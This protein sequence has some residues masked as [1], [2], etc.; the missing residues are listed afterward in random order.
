MRKHILLLSII[1][2]FLNTSSA[3]ASILLP[4][5]EQPNYY[6][7]RDRLLT[8]SLNGTWKFKLIKD[9]NV[10]KEY[11]GWEQPTFNTSQ[12]D[13]INVPGNWETQGLK[14]PE[15]GRDLEEYIGLYRTTFKYNQAWNHKNVIL[16]FDGV[17]FGYEC[18]INGNKVGSFGSA[19]N[20]CQ[21][22]ITPFLNTEGDNVLSV[23]VSTR[24]FGWLF[25]TNDCWSL[26]GIT[27]DVELFALDNIY[28]EDVTYVSDVTQD[29]NAGIKV[30]INVN[31]FKEDEKTYHLNIS[32][33]DP[34]NNHVLVFSQAIKNEVNEYSFE[35]MLQ[36][37]KLWTAETPNLYRLEVCIVNNDGKII[38]RAN[39][40]VGIRSIYVD[41][42][43]L[44]INHTPILLRGVCMNEI[45]PKLGRASPIKS[46]VD[47]WN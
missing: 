11:Q 22:N 5:E 8:Q 9:L 14:T 4:D 27:R 30:N 29:L 33:S 26:A 7:V 39:E 25:D 6:P 42:F 28:L 45:D 46:F 10:P 17:H 1:F 36:K 31:R 35:G 16:R 40:R 2:L 32:L 37:P 38:Q 20:L 15:Y 34:Q 24:S 44:K 43:D 13:N 12:W 21:F 47:I 18:Y 19:F 23:K 41:G 3:F